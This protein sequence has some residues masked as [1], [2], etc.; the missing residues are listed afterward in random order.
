MGNEESILHRQPKRR[1]IMQ[2]IKKLGVTFSKFERECNLMPLAS[3][4]TM[5]PIPIPIVSWLSE[6][7][8]YHGVFEE[9]WY[10]DNKSSI[11]EFITDIGGTILPNAEF[12]LPDGKAKCSFD[13]KWR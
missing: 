2:A 8:P 1:Y 7:N 5:I 11:D 9:K 6:C 3:T 10:H 4:T 12:Y 13:L